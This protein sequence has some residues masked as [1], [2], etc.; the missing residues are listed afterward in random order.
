MYCAHHEVNYKE[1]NFQA[2]ER[3]RKRKRKRNE[4]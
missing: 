2:E 1:T 4:N 3:K